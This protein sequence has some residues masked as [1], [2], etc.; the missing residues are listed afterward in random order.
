M[1]VVEFSC[2]RLSWLHVIGARLISFTPPASPLS[3][4]MP[5]PPLLMDNLHNL[6]PMDIVNP[7]EIFAYMRYFTCPYTRAWPKRSLPRNCHCDKHSKLNSQ[8]SS[9]SIL[10]FLHHF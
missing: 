7:I 2:L 10:H 4:A 5:Q 8:G 1:E 6:T 3:Y 9:T